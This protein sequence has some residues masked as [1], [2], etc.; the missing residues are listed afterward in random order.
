MTLPELH[1]RLLSWATA[2]ARQAD[3][4]AARA[5]HFGRYGEP[6]E[7]DQSYERRMNGM[8][9][10]YLYEWRPSPLAP[11][12]L[13]R[14]IAEEGSALARRGPRH[15]GRA[16]GPAPRPLRGEAGAAG[17]GARAPTRSPARCST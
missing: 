15:P 12:T 4:L 6:H 3:L 2:P 16:G 14:F 7:E 9:D 11:T 17:P 13:E 5:D 8:L 1:E 10:F